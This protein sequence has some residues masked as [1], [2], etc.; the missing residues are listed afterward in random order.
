MF[1]T[2]LVPSDGSA[3]SEK[4][5]H[6]AIEVVAQGGRKV[7]GLA[8][9]ARHPLSVLPEIITPLEQP[10]YEAEMRARAQRDVQ[11]IADA[12]HAANV[13]CETAVAQSNSPDVEIA[14][15]AQQ[16][17]CD[18]IF[19]GSHEQKGLEHLFDRG[20]TQKILAHTTI[21]VMVF[22]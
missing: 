18:A 1:K 21:P 14:A 22:R 16:F 20:V 8:V 7:V 3:L 15:A 12:A 2:I 10:A 19:I 6:A 4:A 13:Q 17:G 11:K 5:M 9:A